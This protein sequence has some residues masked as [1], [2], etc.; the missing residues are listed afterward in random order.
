MRAACVRTRFD[1]AQSVKSPSVA[2]PASIRNS[3]RA[4]IPINNKRDR[5]GVAWPVV[6]LYFVFSSCVRLFRLL[7]PLYFG[8]QQKKTELLQF[9]PVLLL[10]L[11]LRCWI[12]LCIVNLL[13]K[14]KRFSARKGIKIMRKMY[15]V[16]NKN[17][18]LD[19]NKRI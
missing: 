14:T 13:L 15:L 6:I 9:E 12:G 5:G 3:N 17:I 4:K 16:N 7:F 10:T 1:C 19:N 8:D 11:S 2:W 18:D